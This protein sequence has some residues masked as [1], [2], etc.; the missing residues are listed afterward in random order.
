MWIIGQMEDAG[1]YS[2]NI[3]AAKERWASSTGALGPGTIGSCLLVPTTGETTVARGTSESWDQSW[4]ID[5]GKSAGGMS[6]NFTIILYLLF[7]CLFVLLCIWNESLYKKKKKKGTK[8]GEEKRIE[9]KICVIVTV[10]GYI[11]TCLFF[12][13][14]QLR[15]FIDMW[16]KSKHHREW[17]WRE[18][19][20]WR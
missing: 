16:T 17:M 10:L 6:W 13:L 3:T 4:S 8:G 12:L 18:I 20:I 1:A 9:M 11:I 2:E 7:I 14:L 5:R 15:H 19:I